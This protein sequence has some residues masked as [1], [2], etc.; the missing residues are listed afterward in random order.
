MQKNR[1]VERR[2]QMW[3]VKWFKLKYPHI[4]IVASANGGARD[5]RSAYWMKQEGVLAG[6]PDLQIFASRHGFNGLLIEFKPART[7]YRPPG[8]VSKAQKEIINQLNAAN[9]LTKVCFGIDEAQKEINQYLA[10]EQ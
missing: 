2:E 3:L 9:Y 1:Q 5:E 8:R 6:M 10:N 4:L 7:P